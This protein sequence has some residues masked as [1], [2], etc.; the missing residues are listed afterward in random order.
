MRRQELA[1]AQ[2]RIKA[3]K[4]AAYDAAFPGLPIVFKVIGH[5]TAVG[6][7]RVLV[8]GPPHA[9][10]TSHAQYVAGGLREETEES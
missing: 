5:D 7:R 10:W 9:I 8:D 2:I 6:K 4:R 1:G 3:E